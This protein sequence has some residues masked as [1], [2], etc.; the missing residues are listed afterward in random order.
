MEKSRPNS[1]QRGICIKDP[2]TGRLS[3]LSPNVQKRRFHR[4]AGMRGLS[5]RT[6]SEAFSTFCVDSS[7][8]QREAGPESPRTKDGTRYCHGPCG[9]SLTNERAVKAVDESIRICIRMWK[10][11]RMQPPTVTNT[12]WRRIFFSFV[13]W[14]W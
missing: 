9:V 10:R 6:Y 14:R 7:N 4:L 1:A 13:N 3:S 5:R 2:D 8:L 11:T 12:F